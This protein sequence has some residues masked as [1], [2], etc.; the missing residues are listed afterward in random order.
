ML[1]V[2]TV[3]PDGVLRLVDAEQDVEVN[4]VV[5]SLPLRLRA[6]EERGGRRIVKRTRGSCGVSGAGDAE[7]AGVEKALC[8]RDDLRLPK[9]RTFSSMLMEIRR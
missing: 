3:L 5:E 8:L 6:K 2:A 7:P 4:G 1:G 9:G